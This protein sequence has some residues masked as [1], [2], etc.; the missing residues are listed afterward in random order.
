MNE[1]QDPL[2]VIDALKNS[3]PSVFRW[4]GAIARQLRQH[5]V[6]IESKTSGYATTDALTL[7]DLSVQEM[8]VAALRDS[9]PVLKSCRLEAEESVGDLES[10][11]Q[12]APLTIALDPIDGT[13]QF[14]DKTADGYAIMLNLRNRETVLYSLVYLPE[15]GAEGGWVEAMHDG[16]S[17]ADVTAG[18][19]DWSM[20]ARDVIDAMERITPHSRGTSDRIYMI[21]FQDQDEEKARLVSGTGLE[22]VVP[23]KMP[24]SIYPLLATGEFAGSLI[25]TPNIYDFPTSLL[26]ARAFGGDAVWVHNGESV[27]FGELWMDDRAGMLRLP[28]IVA[29]AIDPAQLQT[30]VEVAR[31]WSRERYAQ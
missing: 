4:A 5:N 12:D 6:G 8:V 13:K 17:R 14:R 21:G 28:G 23:S 19:D 18:P 15:Q 7:A 24:D 25:H 1:N 31:D 26:I 16:H 30:L 20:P 2:S 9:D 11:A 27:H 10:F 3:M 29:C 22:G